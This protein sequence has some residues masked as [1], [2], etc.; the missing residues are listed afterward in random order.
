MRE[1]V[2]YLVLAFGSVTMAVR[3]ERAA[4]ERGREGRLIPLPR[5]ISA[6][7]GMAWRAPVRE[8]EALEQLAKQEGIAVEGWYELWL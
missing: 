3:M 6:S 8:R 5:E 1:K 7:C 4:R 2:Q